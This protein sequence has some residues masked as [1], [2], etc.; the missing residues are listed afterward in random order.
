MF[1][2]V[3]VRRL[4]KKCKDHDDGTTNIML[5]THDVSDDVNLKQITFSDTGT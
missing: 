3:K 5:T 4:C 2:D 1:R